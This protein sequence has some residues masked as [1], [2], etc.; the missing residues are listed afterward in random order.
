VQRS[1]RPQVIL[2]SVAFSVFLVGTNS[3]AQAGTDADTKEVQAYVLTE[4]G[5]TKYTQAIQ[6]LAALPEGAPGRCDD[7]SDAS[8]LADSVALLSSTPGAEAAIRSAGLTTREYVVF[9]WS[10][11]STALAA[12]VSS[13]PGG[14]LPPGAS[15]ANVDFYKKHEA[16]VEQLNLSQGSDSCDEEKD[17]DDEEESDR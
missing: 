9:S 4:A 15:Q 16:A 12:W 1:F 14:Q 8:S 11:I 17:D 5:L 7:E 2:L 3:H 10:L 6:N 13:E